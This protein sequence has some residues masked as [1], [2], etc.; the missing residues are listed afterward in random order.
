MEGRP[1]PGATEGGNFPGDPGV[2]GMLV[3][4]YSSVGDARPLATLLLLPLV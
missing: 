3:V 4:F 2:P 1:G